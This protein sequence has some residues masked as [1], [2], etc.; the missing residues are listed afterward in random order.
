M[1]TKNSSAIIGC[2][3][4]IFTLNKRRERNWRFWVVCCFSKRQSRP[5]LAM[6][7]ALFNMV[8]RIIWCGVGGTKRR[9]SLRSRRGVPHAGWTLRDSAAT[10]KLRIV[11]LKS[12]FNYLSELR[13][14]FKW[15]WSIKFGIM[16]EH[17][18]GMVTE[19]S[20]DSCQERWLAP[21]PTSP[22][23]FDRVDT[24]NM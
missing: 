23:P 9:K 19:R 8:S 17:L 22:M 21:E 20:R 24:K 10:T 14:H 12:D 16:G 4:A 2:F 6:N 7:Q 18:Y 1:Q 11:S 13:H 3:P 15:T 5:N